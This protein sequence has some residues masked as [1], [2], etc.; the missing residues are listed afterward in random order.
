[1]RR[2][3]LGGEIGRL[4]LLMIKGVSLFSTA[5]ATVGMVAPTGSVFPVEFSSDL[6][7]TT[8]DDAR[9]PMSGRVFVS[10][11]RIRVDTNSDGTGIGQ[12][13]NLEKKESWW[14]FYNI[15]TAEDHSATTAEFDSF[16][17]VPKPS[18]YSTKPFDPEH[19]CRTVST[20][21]TCDKLGIETVNGRECQ[22]MVI[23]DTYGAIETT[24]LMWVDLALDYPIKVQSN[25]TI[26]ELKNI[27]LGRQPDSVFE[28]PADFKRTVFS[29]KSNLVMPPV[30]H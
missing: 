25:G 27:K 14:I 29:I 28:I 3:I 30:K 16:P 13:V 20:V 18:F 7:T 4:W 6:V 12:I 11:A 15:K 8:I 19:A 24:W 26:V 5:L 17:G 23:K 1:M 10:K 22:K 21:T 2:K 9:P